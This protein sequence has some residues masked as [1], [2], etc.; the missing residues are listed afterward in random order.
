MDPLATPSQP[1]SA[2]T[3]PAATPSAPAA[4]ASPSSD[5][6][7]KGPKVTAQRQR[8]QRGAREP[9]N[10]DARS[11]AMEAKQAAVDDEGDA[12][13]ATPGP[14]DVDVPQPDEAPPREELKPAKDETDEKH[15]PAP[16]RKAVAEATARA[17]RIEADA[18]R[19]I[20]AA[21]D[22]LRQSQTAA[23]T[24]EFL[25]A[26]IAE[27]GFDIDPQALELHE[28]RVRGEVDKLANEHLEK[29]RS[30]FEKKQGEQ[31][32]VKLKTD[33]ASA[34]EKAG[35]KVRTLEVEY[36]LAVRSHQARGETG[37]EP[38][39]ADVVKRMRAEALQKQATT[40]K[41]APSLVKSVASTTS[42]AVPRDKTL[43]GREA[44]LR[45]HGTDIH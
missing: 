38:T 22:T 4:K 21:K 40:N 9:S 12:R 37:P 1:A 19:H 42:V 6:G 29:A 14:R 17:K 34:A 11:D 23:K 2:P 39:V 16:A 3:A 20:A 31:D 32:F 18:H 8:P 27:A 24:I 33:I 41:A 25:K 13:A 28:H 43:A 30:E 26:A 45:S 36:A 44:F 35:V 7:D 10:L 15:W 5:K